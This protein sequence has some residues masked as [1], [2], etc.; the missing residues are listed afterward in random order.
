MDDLVAYLDARGIDRAAV[1][2]V[3]FGGVL[4]LELAAR[5]PDRVAAV[6]AYEPPYGP[7]ADPATRAAFAELAV[8]VAR[9]PPD[10]RRPRGRRDVPA[11]RRR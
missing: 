6:V 7:V 1:V 4:G 2:G 11:R 10:G 8:A 3:S 5:H 9:G